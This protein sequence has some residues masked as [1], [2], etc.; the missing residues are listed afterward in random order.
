MCLVVLTAAT[1][2]GQLSMK[3]S[4]ARLVPPFLVTGLLIVLC[5][6]GAI[7]SNNETLDNGRENG[8]D[9]G[10]PEGEGEKSSTSEMAHETG[11]CAAVCLPLYRSTAA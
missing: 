8:V 5:L 7:A 3:A 9:C 6:L 10:A 4:L 2:I 1:G 11:S